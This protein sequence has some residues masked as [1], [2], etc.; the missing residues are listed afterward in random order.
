MTGSR[1]YFPLRSSVEFFE[2]SAEVD[3]ATRVKA[4]AVLFDEV[5]LEAGQ[6]II[7]VGDSIFSGVDHRF[8]WFPI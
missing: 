4:A 7:S 1:L 8:C 5:T 2:E 3:P 6:I